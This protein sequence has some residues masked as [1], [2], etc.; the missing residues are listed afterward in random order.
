MYISIS[1]ECTTVTGPVNNTACVFP[2]KFKSIE[3]NTCKKWE[4]LGH[5][6]EYWCATE[7]STVGE[8]IEGRWGNC[9]GSKRCKHVE[10]KSPFS[11]P[12]FLRILNPQ[13]TQCV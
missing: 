5:E 8:Y 9:G 2:F 1:T 4:D 7:V 6:N 11:V 12:F 10:G 13:K 3:Y